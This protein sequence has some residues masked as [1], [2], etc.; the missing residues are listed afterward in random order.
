M[1]LPAD[2]DK[3]ISEMPAEGLCA[4]LANADDYLPEA[5]AAARAELG[6]RN[7]PES[8]VASMVETATAHRIAEQIDYKEGPLDVRM[9]ILVLIFGL[10]AGVILHFY[11][12]GK[13]CRRK[14]RQSLLWILYHFLLVFGLGIVGFTLYSLGVTR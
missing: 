8:N 3:T 4:M 7:L 5:I 6:R 2:F 13:A 12:H 1:K 11:Y 9:R 10:W 14:A